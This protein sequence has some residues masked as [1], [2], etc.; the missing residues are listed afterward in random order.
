[1]RGHEEASGT[2]YVPKPLMEEWAEKDPIKNYESFLLQEDI[3]TEKFRDETKERI[4]KEI[5]EA[6]EIAFSE[7]IPGSSTNEELNDLFFPSS[8]PSIRPQT[9]V[10][11]KKRFVDAI[12]DGLRQSLERHKG[13]VFMGQDIAE[14]G[15]AFKISEGFLKDFGE[16]RIRNT[17]ICE[18]AIVGAGLGLS[19]MGRKSV[20][21]MQFADFVTCG[22]NQIV[23]NLAKTHYRWGQ[24][25]DVVIRMPTGAGVNAGPFHSQ[26]NEAW[27]FHT[28]GLKIVYPSNPRDAK[29]LLAAAIEDP[30][31]VLFFE[32]KKLYRS[33]SDTIP[34][35]FYTLELGKASIIREGEDVSIITYGYGVHWAKELAEKSSHSIEIIDLCSLIPWDKSAVKQT[36][37]KT[38]KV[39]ILHEDT[40]TGGIGGEISAWISENCFE[41]LDG[42]VVRVGSLDTPIP[43]SPN[44]EENFLP[45]GRLEQKLDQLVEF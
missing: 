19:I 31:P 24:K 30:N 25:A 10:S 3:L 17:P 38:G 11:S 20:I 7:D 36:V 32:H 27:F 33:I 45:N 18:S 41:F 35:D 21:E 13:L 40:L 23:N 12:S 9:E 15:G 5:E 29:G 26:S 16:E 44:L 34:D 14:Y 8:H 43:F 37:Q 42:P 39:L 2:K 1:M 28:P 6:I 4:R 22:F